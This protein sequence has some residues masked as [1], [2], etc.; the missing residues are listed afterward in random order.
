MAAFG[1]KPTIPCCLSNSGILSSLIWTPKQTWLPLVS[2][3]PCPPPPLLIAILCEQGAY[4]EIQIWSCHSKFP[5]PII[6]WPCPPIQPHLLLL[7]SFWC[8]DHSLLLMLAQHA[9][10]LLLC[11]LL[12]TPFF[13]HPLSS[14]CLCRWTL[15]FSLKAQFSECFSEISPSF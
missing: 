9:N 6:I 7:F 13:S 15:Y 2:V 8:L 1:L 3:F 4:S 14:S 5:I 11:L 10:I 12:E